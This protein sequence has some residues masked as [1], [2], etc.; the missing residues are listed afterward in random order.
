MNQSKTTRTSSSK[1]LNWDMD[2]V[3]NQGSK[4]KLN[5]K[6]GYIS[7]EKSSVLKEDKGNQLG[8]TL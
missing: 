6:Y 3:T 7:T 4:L 5:T 8:F 2:D 1:Q